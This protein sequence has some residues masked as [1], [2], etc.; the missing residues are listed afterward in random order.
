MYVQQEVK[1]DVDPFGDDMCK[2]F[3][4]LPKVFKRDEMQ[5]RSGMLNLGDLDKVRRVWQQSGL[6]EAV[7][8]SKL[9]KKV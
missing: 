2:L 6:I 4:K 8:Y 1:G 7:P 5:R 3:D 9:W